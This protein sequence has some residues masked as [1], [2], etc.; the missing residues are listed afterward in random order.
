VF[1][2][3]TDLKILFDQGTPVPLRNYIEGHYVFT[4]HQLGWSNLHNGELLAHAELE[5]FELLMTTD[6]NLV[7]QQ[8]LSNRKIAIIVL[9]STSWPRIQRHIANINLA[10]NSAVSNSYQTIV[11][12]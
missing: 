10:I 9:S 12:G 3:R 5:G 1:P 7:Y 4:A 2:R 11:I 8:N 6:S